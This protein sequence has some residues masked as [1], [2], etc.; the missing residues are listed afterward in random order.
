MVCD[1]LKEGVIGDDLKESI[2]MMFNKMKQQSTIPECMKTATITMLQKKKCKLDINN[3]RGIFVT[4]VL[5]TILMKLL[6]VR[7]Y[8]KVAHNMSDS[9]IGAQKRKSVR[10]HLFVLIP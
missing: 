2:I 7:T 5:R 3:W 1:I 6:H 4:S 8:Q 10:N 9:Q